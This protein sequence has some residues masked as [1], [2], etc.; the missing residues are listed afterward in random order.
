MANSIG[1][2]RLVLIVIN[3][4]FP[5][6]YFP[7]P[8]FGHAISIHNILGHSIPR[9]HHFCI[10][11]PYPTLP[12]TPTPTPPLANTLPLFM[13][14]LATKPFHHPAAPPPP[15]TAAARLSIIYITWK[16]KRQELFHYRKKSLL[17]AL[18][19]YTKNVIVHKWTFTKQSTSFV[20]VI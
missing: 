13:I 2:P 19:D 7:C 9:T 5:F 18:Y 11:I 3:I 15:A 16:Y 8:S 1:L 17:K 20:L 12:P 10:Q 6:F 4:D 14:L